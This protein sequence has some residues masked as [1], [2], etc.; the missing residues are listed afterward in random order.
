MLVSFPLDVSSPVPLHFARFARDPPIIE[1][2]HTH[3]GISVKVKVPYFPAFVDR[4]RELGGRWLPQDRAWSFPARVADEVRE[5]VRTHFG[6]EGE[7]ADYVT[8]DLT[9]LQ[10]V[11]GVETVQIA[12]V[13][14]AKPDTRFG[15]GAR[16]L[17]GHSLLDGTVEAIGSLVTVTK[18]SRFRVRVPE[19]VLAHVDPDDWSVDRV[20]E[21]DV[22]VLREIVTDLESRLGAAKRELA[23]AESGGEPEDAG[24]LPRPIDANIPDFTSL[25]ESC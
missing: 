7:P 25:V 6:T 14:L 5:A 22:A 4:A 16:V 2:G 19:A 20:V 11:S 1:I 23:R 8:V 13:H 9:A 12:Y 21:Y 18:G 24:Q 3:S 15:S 17:E 10:D